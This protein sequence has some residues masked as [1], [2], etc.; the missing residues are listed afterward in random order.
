MAPTPA[1]SDLKAVREFFGMDLPEMKAEWAKGG[2]TSKDRE[3][4]AG[5]IRDGSL[6][7]PDPEAA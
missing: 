1:Q 7:Y 2:L 3:Q 5:G 4:V 6:T